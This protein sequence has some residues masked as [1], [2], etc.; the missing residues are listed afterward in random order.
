MPR[1]EQITE[2]VTYHGEGAVWHSSFGEGLGG[3]RWVDM[4]EGDVL[5]VDE[6]TGSVQ[7][8]STGSPA[9]CVVRP[10][11]K[12]GFIVAL[13]RS[14]AAYDTAGEREWVTPDLWEGAIRFNE[15][16]VDPAGRLLVGQMAYDQ[17]DGAASMFRLNADRSVEKLFGGLTVSNGLGFTADGSRAYYADSDTGRIDLFDVTADG[18]LAG[19]RPFVTLPEGAGSPDGLCV[20]VDG[21]FWVALY[22]GHAVRRYSAEG[23]LTEVVEVGAAR[24]TSCALTADGT[25]YITTSREGL[26]PHEE[27]AAG[28]LFRASV[29]IAG[30]PIRT[31]DI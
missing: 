8:L 27:P 1:T 6:Q 9:A 21:G 23:E 14:F 13:E 18:D 29:G 24:V 25:L 17:A 5:S 4:M 28:A 3:L 10:R 26:E 22:N 2:S 30:V 15:G 20:D 12:G 7:R 11:T 31:V 19:R 16:G